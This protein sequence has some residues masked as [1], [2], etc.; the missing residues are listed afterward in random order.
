M[1][2]QGRRPGQVAGPCNRGWRTLWSSGPAA[3][4]CWVRGS[5]Y[6]ECRAHADACVAVVRRAW[7]HDS[8]TGRNHGPNRAVRPSRH[9][10]PGWVAGAQGGGRRRSRPQR[11]GQHD[12]AAPPAGPG[13]C[14]LGHRPR[15]RHRAG[16]RN[17]EPRAS[18]RSPTATAAQKAG[19]AP[20]AGP[21]RR[22]PGIPGGREIMLLAHAHQ[23]ERFDPG[24]CRDC[25]RD[26]DLP[27]HY[28]L[29]D[30]PVGVPSGRGHSFHPGSTFG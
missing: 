17:V 25:A 2:D 15:A 1:V 7:R 5:S 4:W 3:A 8:T 30:A 16:Q 11:R 6:A 22:R 29:P 21:G 27:D 24:R 12:H 28:R 19:H 18:S 13:P 23:P 26:S 14:Q 10:G 9:G 20:L